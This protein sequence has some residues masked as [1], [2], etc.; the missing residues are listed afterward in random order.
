MLMRRGAV[1]LSLA[2]LVLAGCT[3]NPEP[4]PLPEPSESVGSPSPSSS[5]TVAAPSLPPEA[6]GTTEASA[7]A[8]VGHYVEAVNFGMQTGDTS[9]LARLASDD[10]KTCDAIEQRIEE[11]Y[12]SGGRLAGAGWSIQSVN[13]LSTGDI[14]Q[15]LLAV[16]I[17]IAAQTMYADS[18]SP[19][20][21]SPASQGNLDFH[22]R[23]SDQT[24]QVHR[25]EATQ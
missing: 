10:C 8:F 3:S 12:E 1:G 23:R 13:S 18:T 15:P 24:W 25:L 16:S 11:V 7:K 5:P 4:S 20:S 17:D 14:R 6:K 21:Q 19:P 22:L 9:A 2:G